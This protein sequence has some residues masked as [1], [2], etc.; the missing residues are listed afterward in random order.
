M[1]RTLL[2]LQFNRL[3]PRLRRALALTCCLLGAT[4]ALFFGT[5]GEAATP[6]SGTVTTANTTANPLVYT[7]GPFNVANPSGAAALQCSPNP[8]F[9]CDD[10]A[11]DVNV[12]NG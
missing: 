1:P 3:P 6:T 5:R 10:F 12:P 7:A 8:P 11:L 2:H 4:T 9:A